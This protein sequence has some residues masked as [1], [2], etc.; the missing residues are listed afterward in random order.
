MVF[1]HG[2]GT[3][4]HGCDGHRGD[5]VV[6]CRAR[7]GRR[8]RSGVAG[9]PTPPG[10]WWE[11]IV[12]GGP[13]CDRSRLA[14]SGLCASLWCSGI[15]GSATSALR[16]DPCSL[17]LTAI[18]V[19]PVHLSR[20][21]ST[22]VLGGRM[23]PCLACSS[24]L[25]VGCDARPEANGGS[26]PELQL[27][28]PELTEALRRAERTTAA[29]MR[30]VR[31]STRPLDVFEEAVELR[32]T[33][34]YRL[35]GRIWIPRTGSGP[36]PALVWLGDGASGVADALDPDAPMTAPEAARAGWAVIAIDLAGRGDSTGEDDFGG[37]E[38]ADDVACAVRHLGERADVDRNRVGIVGLGL[39]APVGIAAAAGW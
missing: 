12:W 8:G 23:A 29:W 24:W 1:P 34:G 14:G 6:E 35:C 17:S 28:G 5:G 11:C 39:G 10:A 36:R 33:C 22:A 20:T 3:N 38:H 21:G 32:S 30:R 9:D 27:I 25:E 31:E 15:V 2:R 13:R 19:A 26:M 7:G 4:G 16:F 18:S 37:P